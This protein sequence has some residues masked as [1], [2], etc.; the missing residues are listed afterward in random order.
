MK[1]TYNE[2]IKVLTLY[3]EVRYLSK[4]L[5]S[6]GLNYQQ[7]KVLNEMLTNQYNSNDCRGD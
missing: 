4:P 7:F 2:Y 6:T 1:L 3:H 5:N